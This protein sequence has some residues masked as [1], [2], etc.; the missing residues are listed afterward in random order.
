MYGQ[1]VD[2][3]QFTI[4]D[5]GPSGLDQGKGGK[6]LFVPPGY[7]KAIPPGYIVVKSPNYRIAFAF[8][9]IVGKGKT[10]KQAFNYAQTLKMY[11]LSQAKSPPQQRFIDPTAT[12]Q[13]YSTLTFYDERYFQD[14]YDIVTVEPVQS[15]DKLMM[16]MLQT[17][18]IERGKPYKPDD[19]TKKAMRQAAVDA[20]AYVQYMFDHLPKE[21]YYWSDRHYVSLLQTDK[22]NTF[23]FE[24]DDSIDVLSRAM[25]YAW[26]TYMPKELSAS[27]ATQYL[28]A[29]ADKN[30]NALEAGKL[31]K[32][33]VP[34]NMPIKQF[35]AMTL[36]DRATFSF[37]Y[38]DS[39]RTT[40]SSYDVDKMIKN[41]D[42]TVT[43]Y[44]G[45]KAPDGFETNWIPTAGKRPLPCMR[46]Y[47]P[48]EALNNKSF[49]MPDFELINE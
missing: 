29:M 20:W 2:A 31:Y 30:G 4:A 8:R 16:G 17:L 7:S 48:T 25:E 1:V 28:M 22:K 46:F 38:T 37:I 27:P 10:L 35:W 42:G 23:T 5:V 36:Y 14:L 13:T 49:T 32:L 43:I 9:S 21:K 47:G 11:Y 39:E 24:Y 19:K 45:P 44:I 26:C 18:G 12:K 15:K 41:T 33:I 6:Y 3:W 40:L 34:K